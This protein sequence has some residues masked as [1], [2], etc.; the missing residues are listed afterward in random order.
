[1]SEKICMSCMNMVPGDALSCSACGFNGSQQN[2]EICLAIGH[3]L[4]N[5]YVVGRMRESDGDSVCYSGYDLQLSK[6]VEIREFLPVNGCSRTAE[7]GR[8]IPKIGAE[9]HFKTS[10]MDF[11]D[12]Y[13]NLRKLTYEEGIVKTLDFFEGNQT[14]YAVLDC[15]DA[16]TLREF[17]GLKSGIITWEQC[18]TIMEPV[19]NA[20][21]S[22]HSVNLIHR[23]V[24]PDTIFVARS[25]EIKL[26][27]FATNSVRTKG[28]DFACRLYS[29]YSA[30]EQ[31]ATNMWHSTGTDV[32]GLAATVY[33]CITGTVPQDADQRRVY[34][35]LLPPL[36][37]NST[38][39]AHVSKALVMAMLVDQKARTQTVLDLKQM[40][41]GMGGQK[42]R[43]VRTEQPEDQDDDYADDY[44]DDD[45]D[46]YESPPVK[47]GRFLKWITIISAS[48]FLLMFAIYFIYGSLD[49]TVIDR[50]G[51]EPPSFSEFLVV[52]DYEGRLLE[53]LDGKLDT[54]NFVIE[55]EPVF[56]EGA[57]EGMV[58]STSPAKNS[59]INKGDPIVL[60]VN[61][62]RV[63][64]MVDFEGLTR[65]NAEAALEELGIKNNYEFLHEET[66]KGYNQTIFEQSV[67]PGED[68]NIHTDML[69]LTIA[70]NPEGVNAAE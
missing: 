37:L 34:D 13:R 56:S 18:R 23:G 28:T 24:S 60:R 33:R 63:I 57:P 67:E 36:E 21:N 31:Y 38:I 4:N 43:T 52:P 17:L 9:L 14:A 30:P 62:T 16:V 27:G 45:A 12:L 48:V 1:M 66:K 44:P 55:I 20:L 8:L 6:I 49:Q 11:S 25:G 5:R 69:T 26:F 51:G 59:G 58:I 40:L 39:P 50:Q 70:L 2:P 61:M 42:E 10:L 7:T 54:Y 68:F 3:R 65:A 19:F 41:S 53:E 35:N 29:G 15:F 46:D 47:S 22:I 64:T 32:Y